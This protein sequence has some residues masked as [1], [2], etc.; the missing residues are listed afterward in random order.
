M[1]YV[2]KCRKRIRYEGVFITHYRAWSIVVL[3]LS[4]A[5]VVLAIFGESFFFPIRGKEIII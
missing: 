5:A 3:L 2:F 1:N 4:R